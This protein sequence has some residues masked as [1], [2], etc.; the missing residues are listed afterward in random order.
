MPRRFETSDVRVD[1]Q[2]MESNC[3][4]ESISANTTSLCLLSLALHLVLKSE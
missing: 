3:N 4:F 1:N 2:R